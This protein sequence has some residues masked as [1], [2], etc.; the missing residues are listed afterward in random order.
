MI[1]L[2]LI[3]LISCTPEDDGEEVFFNLQ[4]NN[5]PQPETK[6]FSLNLVKGPEAK[7]HD[8]NYL[9][10]LFKRVYVKD[11][12]N[13]E[14]IVPKK[15]FLKKAFMNNVHLY[16]GLCDPNEQ[17]IERN[18]VIARINELKNPISE[19]TNPSIHDEMR[20]G[21]S[22]LRQGWKVYVCGHLNQGFR[23]NLPPIVNIKRL[24]NI[25]NEVPQVNTN[26]IKTA[27]HLFNPYESIGADLL[28]QLQKIDALTAEELG[29]DPEGFTQGDVDAGD[30][31]DENNIK[32]KK[33]RRVFFILC[34]DPDNEI[35]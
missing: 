13:N 9:Y 30:P 18:N 27:Y 35:I 34:L 16:G 23:G 32:L 3:F 19:C 22:M 25:E 6:P 5:I 17:L 7:L 31:L 15:E 1:W 21:S 11:A 10:D 26:T 12:D 20:K 4:N 24:L 28:N 33:W 14:L 8:R 29:Q 2:L